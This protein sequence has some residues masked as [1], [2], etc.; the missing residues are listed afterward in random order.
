MFDGP[1]GAR[2]SARRGGDLCDRRKIEESH[3][4]DDQR[5]VLRSTAMLSRRRDAA[6]DR[7]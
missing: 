3:R 2:F 6:V 1:R 5:C 7:G 4:A